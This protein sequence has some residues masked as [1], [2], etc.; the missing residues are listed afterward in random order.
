MQE[1]SR[2][3]DFV[4]KSNWLILAMAACVSLA[5][6]SHEVYLGVI[7]GGLIVAVNFHVLKRTIKN[8][9][10]PER[11]SEKG[12]S[13]L[14]NLLVKYYIRFV[15]SGILIFLLISNHIV[16]PLGLLAGLSVVVASIFLATML[17][18]TKILFKEAV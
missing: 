10:S 1:L 13:L 9:L 3:V 4:T 8:S 15:I 17:V 7:S 5:V 18:L 6:A 14:G 11:V 12:S 16:H 2:L